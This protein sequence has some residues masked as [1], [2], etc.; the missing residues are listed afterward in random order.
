MAQVLT[1]SRLANLAAGLIVEAFEDYHTRFKA[2]THRARRRFEE[3]DWAGLQ[4]DAAERLQ[5]YRTVVDVLVEDLRE[6]LGDRIRE[7]LIWVSVKAVY[8][9]AIE[10]RDDWELAETFFNSTTRRIFST[11]GVDPRIMG[12]GPVPA[13][14]ASSRS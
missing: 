14:N 13:V 11:V 4:A 9:G 3:R 1:D 2:V 10:A 5:L 7:T 12:I 8:S 6:R